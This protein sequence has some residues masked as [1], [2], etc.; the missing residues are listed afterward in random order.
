[1]HCDISCHRLKAVKY[2][3]ADY[4]L[5]T[6][7]WPENR[8]DLYHIKNLREIIK[9]KVAD[10]KPFNAKALNQVIKKVG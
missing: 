9:N 1:M 4:S 5:A 8:P 10:E 6:L 3:L 7:D 2:F